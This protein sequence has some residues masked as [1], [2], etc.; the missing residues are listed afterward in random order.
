MR[1]YSKLNFESAWQ[2]RYS[3]IFF[4][5]LFFTFEN[6]WQCRYSLLF[7][8]MFLDL[9]SLLFK[10]TVA[11]SLLLALLF[12]DFFHLIFLLLRMRGSAATLC[13]SFF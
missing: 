6:A 9:F 8:F 3:L 11:V 2:C 13:S 5:Y 10:N 7:F 4:F 1:L 12:L